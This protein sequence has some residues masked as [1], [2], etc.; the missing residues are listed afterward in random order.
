MR[1]DPANRA[2]MTT[3]VDRF[4]G[5]LPPGGTIADLGCG[6]GQHAIELALRG[7]DVI[8]IDYAPAML[9]RARAH[10]RGRSAS[11]DFR[12]C[13]LNE[14]L[15]FAAE[16]L[17]GALCVSVIQAVGDPLSLL[18]QLRD[19]LRPGGHALIE[20]VRYLG[21]LSRGEHLS[22]CDQVING[23]KKLVAKIPGVVMQY[24]PEDVAELCVLAGLE[25]TATHVYD[26]TFTMTARR[27]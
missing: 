14:G 18:G 10:A 23:A 7:F 17:D 8:A 4:A 22:G 1:S 2:Q 9:A 12:A 11:V 6:T 24:Q 13:D 19:A 25:V 15:P 16:T 27:L 21:A 20:S 26:A 3:V 5:R